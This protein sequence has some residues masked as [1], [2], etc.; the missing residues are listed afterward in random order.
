MYSFIFITHGNLGNILTDIVQRIMDEDFSGRIK[1]FS[2][3][4]SMSNIMEDMKEQIKSSIDDFISKNHKVIVFV[5]IFGGSPSNIAFSFAK[6]ENVDVVSGTNLS[7]VMYAVE[8]MNSSKDFST[9]I[10]GIT[11]TGVQ[12]IT[13]AKKLLIKREAL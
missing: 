5:D 13:S 8:H 10:D 7:M 1:V 12:N 6:T 2:V 4:F 9:M 3:D 11:R